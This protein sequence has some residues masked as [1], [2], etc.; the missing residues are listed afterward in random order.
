MPS[1]AIARRPSI[2]RRDA[3]KIAI[4]APLLPVAIT[5]G[6]DRQGR[7]PW[8][9]RNRARVVPA[10]TRAGIDF[11]WNGARQA[12]V[13]CA[14]CGRS[15]DDDANHCGMRSGDRAPRPLI[16]LRPGLLPVLALSVL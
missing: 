7:S 10:A 15:G 3:P 9:E 8:W 11:R 13:F 16:G 6:N 12:R 4:P 1:T 14:I 2:A 5:V